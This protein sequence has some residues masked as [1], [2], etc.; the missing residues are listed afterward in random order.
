LNLPVFIARR[1]KKPGTG[2]FS[3]MIHGIAIVNVAVGLCIMII[4]VI[5][6]IGFKNTI[7]DKVA[8]FNGHIEV[9]KY[10][11][12]STYEEVPLS[13]EME[14]IQ[15]AANLPFIDHIQGVAH[16]VTVLKSGQEIQGVVFKG[17]G[18]DYDFE[19]LRE[20]I[21]EGGPVRFNDSTFSTDILISKKISGLMNIR[22]HDEI[23]VYFI[24]NPVRIRRLNVCGIYDSGMEEFDEKIVFGDIRIVQ[25]L[26]NWAPGHVGTIEIYIKNADQIEAAEQTIFDITDY[27][28]YVDNMKNKYAEL[29]DWLSLINRNVTILLVP[30]LAVI[31]FNM[32]SV[33]II[34]IMERT[35]MIG[36]LK[37]LGASNSQIRRIFI[38]NGTRL[39]Y[40][41]LFW[42]NLAGLG[43]GLLQWKFKLI[44]LD[45]ENYYMR[46]VPIQLDWP[47]ITGLNV[48]ILIIVS[49]TLY[50]P[51]I[52]ISGIRPIKAIRF[53]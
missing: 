22:L 40:Y 26:N 51:S 1:I 5:I 47:V 17:I 12:N 30:L 34:L 35:Q 16:K 29:F 32:I 4:S 10:T 31:S 14:S 46:F 15:E 11:L 37:A 50:I 44:P 43:F 8:A 7:S 41:G 28:L 42:G 13:R 9:T 33:L 3:A 21:I 48:L 36:L 53:N 24:Q 25:L 6:M 2:T 18:R 19:R 20:N 49:L 38:H 23:L 39:I 45:P 52:M 27:D